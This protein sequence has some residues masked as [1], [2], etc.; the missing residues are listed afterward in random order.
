MI[1]FFRKI[2]KRLLKENKFK[3]Y[4]FYALGEI[5]LVVIGIL[6]ALQIN[7]INENSKKDEVRKTYYHQILQDLSKDYQYLKTE[8]KNLN[9]NIELYKTYRT[10]FAQQKNLKALVLSQLKLNYYYPYLKFNTNTIETLQSTGDIKLMPEK[11][12][13]KLI[14]LK[15]E[16]NVFISITSGNYDNFAKGLIEAT[17]LGF[18]PNVI[19]A[20][21]DKKNEQKDI[22]NNLNVEANLDE[23]ALI[24]NAAYG[25]KNITEIDQ[26]RGFEAMLKEIDVLFNL[27]NSKLENPYSSIDSVIDKKIKLEKL[28][29]EGKSLDE[30]I[31]IVKNEDLNNSTYTI[32]E[33]YINSLGYAFLNINQTEKALKVFKL[34]IELY[35]K[36]W[37]TY[38]SY[39]EGLLKIGDTL[40]AVKAYK[41]SLELNPKNEVAQKIILKLK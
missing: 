25:L 9:I 7:N 21:N 10:N 17:K 36:A 15:N 1:K 29:K 18:T 16:Q 12:R 37:N 34:N 26:S 41:K 20:K 24:V 35:P 23:I 3:N 28:I 39:G 22:F 40:N 27:I 6:I 31:E 8:I 5:I 19:L 33:N 2:R 38:D 11:I 4:F 32:S 30:V 13:N 14:D